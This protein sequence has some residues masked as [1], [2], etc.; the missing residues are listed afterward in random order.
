MLSLG[1]QQLLAITRLTLARPSF[2][3]LDRV[4]SSLNAT[5]LRQ[6]LRTLDENSITY[7][8]LAEDVESVELYDAVLEIDADGA[9][10]WKR[11]GLA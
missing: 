4:N 6:A 8:T 10:S 3:M 7:I 11:T 2:A 5:Q 1:E 9:W